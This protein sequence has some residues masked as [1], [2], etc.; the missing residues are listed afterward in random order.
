MTIVVETRSLPRF[1]DDE[2]YAFCLAN[3]GLRIER[4]AN[5]QL[6]IMPP[7]GFETSAHNNDLGRRLGNWNSEHR[8]GIVTDSN[9]GYLLPDGSMRVPDVA[10]LSHQ[11]LATVPPADRKRFAP[12]CPDFVIEL[13][14]ETDELKAAK[15]KMEAWRA[16]GCRLGWLLVPAARE[17]HV[18]RD[19][20]EVLIVP[21]AQPLD[22]GAVLPGFAL[23]PEEV[24]GPA[25]P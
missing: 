19:N 8:L 6:E 3:K 12:V 5:G 21:F 14:S 24:F 2:L 10:W 4:N 25:N 1:T 18:Y 13:L 16:N 17:A 20:G 11:R 9:G 23:A 15:A 22:G 7:T